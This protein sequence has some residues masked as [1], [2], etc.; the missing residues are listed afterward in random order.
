MNDD[1]TEIRRTIFFVEAIEENAA[2]PASEFRHEN[3]RSEDAI[4][5]SFRP[6]L[7]FFSRALFFPRN[8]V[9]LVRMTIAKSFSLAAFRSISIIVDPVVAS[10][11]LLSHTFAATSLP[12]KILE[13]LCQSFGSSARCDENLGLFHV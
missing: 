4:V 5:T 2:S 13:C 9:P 12:S 6:L 11:R 1:P 3:P 8:I 10:A 7:C